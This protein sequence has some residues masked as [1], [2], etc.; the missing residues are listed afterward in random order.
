MKVG[1]LI[2]FNADNWPFPGAHPKYT[3]LG[4]IINSTICCIPDYGVPEDKFK[5]LWADGNITD[6]NGAYLSLVR[7]A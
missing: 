4:I 6:E 2:S 7:S 5:I 1:D 3:S